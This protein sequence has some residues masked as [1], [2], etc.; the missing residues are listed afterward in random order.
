MERLVDRAEGGGEA[1]AGD[2]EAEADDEDEDEDDEDGNGA[3]AGGYGHGHGYGVDD[4]DEDNPDLPYHYAAPA[5]AAGPAASAFVAAELGSGGG[6]VDWAGLQQERADALAAEETE[7]ARAAG[8]AWAAADEMDERARWQQQQRELRQQEQE[9]LRLAWEAEDAEAREREC[10]QAYSVPSEDAEAAAA[11]AAAAAAARRRS[12]RR[13][14]IAA[15]S[16]AF[17]TGSDPAGVTGAALGAGLA[18]EPAPPQHGLDAS[19]PR[20]PRSQHTY[21]YAPT[22]SH[23]HSHAAQTHER[24]QGPPLVHG[25][26]QI[27]NPASAASPARTG[28]AARAPAE[29]QQHPP[30]AARAR[31]GASPA[32]RAILPTSPQQ[33]PA[34]A[35]APA[36]APEASRMR[37]ASAAAFGREGAAAAR[38]QR[39]LRHQVA[40]GRLVTAQTMATARAHTA[41]DTASATAAARGADA[42]AR[43]APAEPPAAV[44]AA[45]PAAAGPRQLRRVLISRT[46]QVSVLALTPAQ[47]TAALARP[48]A[49]RADAR[50]RRLL[51]LRTVAAAGGDDGAGVDR[52]HLYNPYSTAADDADTEAA[53]LGSAAAGGAGLGTARQQQQQQQQGG[54]GAATLPRSFPQPATSSG[55]SSA[56]VSSTPTRGRPAAGSFASVPIGGP[57]PRPAYRSGGL[58][59]LPSDPALWDPNAEASGAAAAGAGAADLAAFSRP[60]DCINC[61]FRPRVDPRSAEL[62]AKAYER[63]RVNT[64]GETA[65]GGVPHYARS[66]AR[67]APEPEPVPVLQLS[68]KKPRKPLTEEELMDRLKA[69]SK[70][71]KVARRVARE[72]DERSKVAEREARARNGTMSAD[73]AETIAKLN[74]AWVKTKAKKPKVEPFKLEITLPPGM[75]EMKPLMER[76]KESIADANAAPARQLERAA[77]DNK[78]LGGFQPTL[79]E[80]ADPRLR[81]FQQ[82]YASQVP[83]T[84]RLELQATALA[85]RRR[86]AEAFH[87]AGVRELSN[88]PRRAGEIEARIEAQRLSLRRGLDVAA[89]AAGAAAGGTDGRPPLAST[90]RALFNRPPETGTGLS[91]DA[92]HDGYLEYGP[93]LFGSQPSFAPQPLSPQQPAPRQ[94]GSTARWDAP[95]VGPGVPIPASPAMALELAPPPAL[96][97][98]VP[99]P[100]DFSARVVI[101]MSRREDVARA[102][103]IESG[104]LAAAKIGQMERAHDYRNDNPMFRRPS[105]I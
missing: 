4:D 50:R 90:R 70:N 56:G 86:D 80:P 77:A 97:E 76:I 16:H 32:A 75:P 100:L 66:F 31:R 88:N 78:R 96:A 101:D 2:D 46:G 59:P 68:G 65:V 44:P 84:E 34:P 1:G 103:A 43:A 35:L 30:A 98:T 7:L 99:S 49:D 33:E 36:P 20:S 74:E 29:E 95:L 15:A 22:H 63:L 93:P 23:R 51:Q 52:P 45:A 94:P 13:S 73:T 11:D 6:G 72:Q 38:L 40:A 105:A 42:S 17:R 67:P 37:P 89:A 9:R 104:A 58:D 12:A 57:R 26:S 61:V 24:T 8:A 27:D 64:A 60:S 48:K 21:T 47:W 53:P 10:P 85:Q 5:R 28:E 25:R 14:S 55:A 87:A 91:G 71:E 3:R 82:Q 41:A 92:G 102:R 18:L 79:P 81:H 39:Y 83:L 62:A 69:L 19:L 54:A